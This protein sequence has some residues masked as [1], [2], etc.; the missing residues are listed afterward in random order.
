MF[1]PANAQGK[2]ARPIRHIQ[3][4]EKTD[5]LLGVNTKSFSE[6]NDGRGAYSTPAPAHKST[7]IHPNN[8]TP[9]P[10]R[11]RVW[12]RL[13]YCWAGHDLI[14]DRLAS[15]ALALVCRHCLTAYPIDW[16]SAW[17]NLP[18]RR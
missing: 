6:E 15:G 3:L 11:V 2:I 16:G 13:L 10:R 5:V 17:P 9:T 7:P 18:R 1:T 8:L 4:L 14:R 12:R